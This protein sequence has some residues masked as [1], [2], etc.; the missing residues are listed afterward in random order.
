MTSTRAH[1]AAATNRQRDVKARTRRPT[2]DAAR[3]RLLSGMPVT[4]RRLEL[5]GVSTAVL[6]GATARPSSCCTAPASSRPAG[7]G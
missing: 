4:E 2:G 1:K 5:A 3:E 6:E 7:Y